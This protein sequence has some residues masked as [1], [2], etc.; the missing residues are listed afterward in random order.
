VLQLK[1]TCHYFEFMHTTATTV[2]TSLTSGA[3]RLGLAFT[4]TF[5]VLTG[6]CSGVSRT[7]LSDA[8]KVPRQLYLYGPTGDDRVAVASEPEEHDEK[9][10]EENEGEVGAD[11]EID[12]EDEDLE[13]EVS[14]IAA[15]PE[16]GDKPTSASA[17][18]I[19]G[20]Y[21]GTDW[22]TI[23]LPGFPDD[24]QID[25]KARVVLAALDKP[26]RYSFAVLDTRSGDELCKIEGTLS[27]SII[28]F[29]EE[30]TCFATILG[31]PMQAVTST[32]IATVE[33]DTL[34][35]TLGVVLTV[36]TPNGDLTGDLDYRFEGKR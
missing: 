17:G 15:E 27:E 4:V 24:E 18:S 30:Q 3:W 16:D 20:S 19:A 22:V 29:D 32:G 26:T 36:S 25:D 12:D 13:V 14:V 2:T 9:N 23:T 7:P 10:D 35:V 11:E 6:G 28:T 1:A 5:G 8:A 33:G 34:T 21:K 31:V